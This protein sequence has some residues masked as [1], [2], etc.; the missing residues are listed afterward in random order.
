[1]SLAP[2]GLGRQLL[3]LNPFTHLAVSYQEILFYRGPFGHWKWLLALGAASVAV[4][5][6]GYF[7]F[8]RLRDSFAEEV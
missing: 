5:F 6:A 3:N 2:A 1:M 8:D 7:V 4:F